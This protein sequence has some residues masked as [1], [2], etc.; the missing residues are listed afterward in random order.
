MREESK[1]STSPFHQ[2]GGSKGQN[3]MDTLKSCLQ[4]ISLNTSLFHL[5]AFRTNT[6]WENQTKNDY[7]REMKIVSVFKAKMLF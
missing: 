5:F 6:Q 2:K 3:T 1:N 4:S 7:V